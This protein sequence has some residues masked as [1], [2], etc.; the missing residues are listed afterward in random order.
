MKYLGVMVSN[1]GS[2]EKEIEARIGN[3][4]RVIERMNNAIMR[5]KELSR[6][7]KIKV[8]NATMMPVLMYGCETWSLTKKQHQRYK[9]YK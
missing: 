8:V 1:D 7:T 9:P 6:N 3:A 2:M 5:R 4:T